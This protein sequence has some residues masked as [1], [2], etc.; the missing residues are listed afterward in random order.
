[1]RFTL[2]TVIAALPFLVAGAPS[3]DPHAGGIRIPITK[4]STLTN[5][6]GTANL[7]ALRAHSE[8]TKAKIMNGFDRYERNTGSPHPSAPRKGAQRRATGSDPLINDNAQLWYGS[9]E[10]GTPP[11][12][13]TVDFDT[14]SSDLFLPGMDCNSSCNG[15]ERYDPSVSS[16]SKDLG[17]TFS[18]EYGDG[19]TVSGEQYSD[20]VT[21]AGLTAVKQTLGAASTYS[22]GF[23]ISSFP[24]DGLMGMGFPQISDFNA[25]PFFQTLVAD[26]VVTEA[27][28]SFKLARSG[29]E[30]FLGGT[31]TDLY[32]GD[33]TF[34]PV[35]TEGYWQVELDGLSANGDTISTG[36]DS[37]IDTGTTLI[38]IDTASADKFYQAI[39]GKS[40]LADSAGQGLYTYPCASTPSISLT[41]GGVKWPV[42]V[43][44][45]NMGPVS[46]GSADCIGGISA[47]DSDEDFWIV[48]DVFL[49]NVYTAFDVGNTQVGFAEL[50]N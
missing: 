23:E 16:T 36:H 45:F 5:P 44:S 6:D 11:Q 25:N 13:H 32:T 7:A 20:T 1:M 8:Y 33:F 42:S 40:A 39:G 28:F 15:H 47:Q 41:F 3:K 49:Q 10:V 30:L 38:V 24:A 2:A 34:V 4:R 48:G 12:F 27:V 9:I 46:S 17:K 43:E 26:G 18:L 14:G 35:T 21:I 31:N 19:S 29:S 50:S 22:T 37:I